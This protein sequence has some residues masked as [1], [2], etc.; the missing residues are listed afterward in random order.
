MVKVK[1][2]KYDFCKNDLIFLKS[3][4]KNKHLFFCIPCKKGFK[5]N[6]LFI[7]NKK[8]NIHLK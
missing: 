8:N 1:K 4:E 7:L 2:Y 6:N 3:E 5:K